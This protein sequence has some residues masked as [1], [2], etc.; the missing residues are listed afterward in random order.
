[1]TTIKPSIIKD[2]IRIRTLLKERFKSL[3]I[4]AK[5]VIKDAEEKGMVF[6]GASLSK[7]MNHGNIHSSLS[8]ENIIW[9]CFR[10]GIPVNLFIGKPV[11]EDKKLTFVLPDYDEKEC[12]NN[13]TKYFNKHVNRDN[14]TKQSSDIGN[15]NS[16]TKKDKKQEKLGKRTKVEKHK[17]RAAKTK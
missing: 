16:S 2:S 9:L 10:Y 8:E 13:L 5:D 7:Y 3:N 4:L 14:K 17:N 6:T 15:E 12:L 1:M 11:L